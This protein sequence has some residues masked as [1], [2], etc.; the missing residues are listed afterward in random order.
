[1][2]RIC[3]GSFENDDLEYFVNNVKQEELSGWF[4]M[5]VYYNNYVIADL[6]M[7]MGYDLKAD[8]RIVDDRIVDELL[9]YVD[10]ENY[11]KVEYLVYCGFRLN[12]KIMVII[13]E[14]FYEFKHYHQ[15]NGFL[16]KI[17]GLYGRCC[18]WEKEG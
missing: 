8:D 1:M 6:I 13:V 16:E 9:Y 10:C 5:C 2:D 11:E 17:I 12:D 18:G 14:W 3:E 7:G 15:D 4:R